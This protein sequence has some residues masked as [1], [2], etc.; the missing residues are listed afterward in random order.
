[1]RWVKEIE[2]GSTNRV[3]NGEKGRF[4]P[5]GRWSATGGVSA[6]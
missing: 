1:M 5:V 4:S 3:V 6:N 2:K